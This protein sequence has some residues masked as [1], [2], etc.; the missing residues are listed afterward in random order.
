MGCHDIMHDMINLN[1]SSYMD[2]FKERGYEMYNI[3][4]K[5][6]TSLQYL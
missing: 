1:T 3:I 5:Y 4:T 6:S 2:L